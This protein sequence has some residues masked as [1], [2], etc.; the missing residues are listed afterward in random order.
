[1][2][3]QKMYD[4]ILLLYSL[5]T[6]ELEKMKKD[7]YE[8]LD[9]WKIDLR[10]SP[11]DARRQPRGEAAQVG[12][13]CAAMPTEDSDYEKLF[14]AIIDKNKY[15]PLTNIAFG[16]DTIKYKKGNNITY[17]DTQLDFITAEFEDRATFVIVHSYYEKIPQEDRSYACL[18]QEDAKSLIDTIDDHLNSQ[19]RI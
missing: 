7:R 4:A 2:D 12:E 11:Q 8:L 19:Y 13:A 17:K 10:G 1:M 3:I 6:E 16:R 15:R 14:I 18:S 5:Q 9:R